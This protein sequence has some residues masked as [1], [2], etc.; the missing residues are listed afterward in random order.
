MV[1]ERTVYDLMENSSN[2]EKV[3]MEATKATKKREGKNP[4][5]QEQQKM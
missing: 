5:L 4:N 3:Q 1:D 2:F